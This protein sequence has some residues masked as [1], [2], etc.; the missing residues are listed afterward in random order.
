MGTDGLFLSLVGFFITLILYVAREV[1][2]SLRQEMEQEL[3]GLNEL[4]DRGDILPL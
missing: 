4:K 1:P 3:A 2:C